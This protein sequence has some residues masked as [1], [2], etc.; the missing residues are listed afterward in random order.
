MMSGLPSDQF[1][2]SIVAVP[3]AL[4]AL[5]VACIV[6]AT[7]LYGTLK[8]PFHYPY[9]TYAF[10]VSGKRNVAIDD[11]IEQ[12]LLEPANR[13][14]VEQHYRSTEQWKQGCAQ[15][16]ESH[17]LKNR[18]REQLAQVMDDEHAFWF[19]ATRTQTRYKQV[20]YVKH[21]FTVQV[22]DQEKRVSYSWLADKMRALETIG[23]ETTLKK[24]HAKEQRRLMTKELRRQI[25]E[26]DNYTCQSCGKYMP[27]EVGL[28]IDHV[29][30]VAQGGKSV[31]SNLQVLCSKCN[32]SKGGKA[33][34]PVWAT[35]DGAS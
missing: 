3:L 19:T 10:D 16:I 32:G 29:I 12:F 31:P 11:L 34:A 2:M 13:A 28:H 20:N 4:T 35:V 1:Y 17:R 25:M 15:F 7:M 8:N 23:Y 9:F 18:R 6:A 21:S 30:P 22:G 27:D 26:R 24:Y 5:L 33:P 14:A